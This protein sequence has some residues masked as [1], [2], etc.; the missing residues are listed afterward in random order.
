MHMDAMLSWN[1]VRLNFR[2]WGGGRLEGG[3]GLMSTGTDMYF[4]FTFSLL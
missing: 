1:T 3:S 2:K 4:T